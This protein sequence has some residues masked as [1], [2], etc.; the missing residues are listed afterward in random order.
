[1]EKKE[2]FYQ[3]EIRRRLAKTGLVGKYDPRHIEVYMR[4]QTSDGCLDSIS[5]DRFSQ[6]IEWS[7]RQVDIDGAESAERFA[8]SEG[9]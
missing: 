7:A 3:A 6:L 5:S 9:F 1:M 8:K 2:S 4:T